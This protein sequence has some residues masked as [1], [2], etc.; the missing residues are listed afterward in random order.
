M[1]ICLSHSGTWLDKNISE[2]EILAKSV[3]GIDLIISGHTHSV[4][5]Q[6]IRAGNTYIVSCGA[7]GRY[8][9]SL[10]LAR[11]PDRTFRALDYRLMPV[12]SALPQDPEIS[13]LEIV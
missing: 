5:N 8:L 3:P 9:G 4:L 2:D 10:T 13:G 12:T 6:Y 7:Y 11:N 1:V